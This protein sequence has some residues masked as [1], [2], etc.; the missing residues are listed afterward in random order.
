MK[1]KS[2]LKKKSPGSDSFLTEFYQTF[3]EE[4]IPTLLKLFHEKERKE[5]CLT[6]SMKPALHYTH[7]KTGQ[8]HIQKGKLQTNLLNEH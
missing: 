4:I 6:H 2:L 1:L 8:G 7:P 3:K 5:Y